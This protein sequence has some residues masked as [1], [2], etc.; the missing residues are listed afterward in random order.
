MRETGDGITLAGKHR[1][2][3]RPDEIPQDAAA[4][5]GELRLCIGQYSGKPCRV[6]SVDRIGVKIDEILG[7]R[8]HHLPHCVPNCLSGPAVFEKPWPRVTLGRK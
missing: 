8:A 5:F 1:N 4:I 2:H 7:A 6:A 3:L